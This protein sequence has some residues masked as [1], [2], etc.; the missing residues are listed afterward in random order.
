M[1]VKKWLVPDVIDP[2]GEICVQIVIPNDTKHIAAFWGALE[3]LGR[4]YNWEDSYATG[5]QAAQ[6]WQAI[7]YTS[8]NLVRLGQNCMADCDDV[9][10][11]LEVDPDYIALTGYQFNVIVSGSQAR[12]VLLNDD[13]DGTPQS[14]GTDIPVGV[15][16]EIELNALCYALE[17]FV[18]FYAV[19]KRAQISRASGWRV[20]LDEVQ[21]AAVDFYNW[22][23]PH[24]APTYLANLFGCFVDFEAAF[25]A[26]A[27]H[28]A[29]DEFACCLVNELDDVAMSEAAFNAAISACAASLTGTAGDIACIFEGDNDLTVFLVY[30]SGYQIALERQN[31]SEELPCACLEPPAWCHVYTG[32]ELGSLWDVRWPGGG[33][34]DGNQWN[35]GIVPNQPP[36]Q[37][38]RAVEIKRD[39]AFAVDITHIEFTYDL[40]KSAHILPDTHGEVIRDFGV[41]V[42]LS[43][44]SW[45]DSVDGNDQ[46]FAWNGEVTTDSIYI[47]CRA[48]KQW[49]TPPLGNSVIKRVV[50][51]GTGTPP[52]EGINC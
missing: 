36:D 1:T 42:V 8:A 39:F 32:A 41:D 16:T 24:I 10:A 33:T 21:S 52:T 40:V 46:I 48:S 14:I 44:L 28:A 6:I 4:G 17:K 38:W 19:S 51:S 25:P 23:A 50:I 43:Q 15:P 11:C 13:Y 45:N 20:M 37:Y 34:F 30:L 31:A 12:D 47:G 7:L 2:P 35:A 27:D 22:I 18:P 29:R 26:L 49:N 3:Q 9:L 5:S